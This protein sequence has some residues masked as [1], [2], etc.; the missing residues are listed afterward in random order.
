[1]LTY[2]RDELKPNLK[3]EAASLKK[4]ESTK[5]SI[6]NYLE[7]ILKK[8]VIVMR[9]IFNCSR[10]RNGALFDEMFRDYIE[11]LKRRNTAGTRLIGHVGVYIPYQ[12]DHYID[13][14]LFF[15]SNEQKEIES[16]QLKEQVIKYWKEYASI[17]AVQIEHFNKRHGQ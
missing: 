2:R 11:N 16:K 7:Q 1:M 14:T 10:V 4:A 15:E 13:A 8:D 3:E 6:Q 17:K 5:A 9:F 12:K